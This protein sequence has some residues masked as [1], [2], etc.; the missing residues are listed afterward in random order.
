MPHMVAMSHVAGFCLVQAGLLVVPLSEPVP[1][2]PANPTDMDP[3]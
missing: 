1:T 2:F 3:S